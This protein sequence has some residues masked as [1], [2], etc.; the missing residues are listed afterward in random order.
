[1]QQN[2]RRGEERR[3]ERKRGEGREADELAQV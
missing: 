2:Q 1:M 3:E